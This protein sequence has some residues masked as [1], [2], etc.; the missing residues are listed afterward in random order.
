[1]QRIII[2]MDEVIA[3]PM[4]KM[5]EWYKQKYNVDVDYEKMIG[6]SWIKGFPEEHQVMVRQ[7]LY[8]PGFFRDLPVMENSVE[9][10]K[11]LNGRYEI[12]IV[13]AAVEF[14][15]SL[16]DK[17]DWLMEHFPFFTWRQLVL[18]G[19]KKMIAGDFMIDDHARHLEHF[20]GKPYLYSAPH[21]LNENRFTRLHNWLEIATVFE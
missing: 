21:N 13:S 2:D 10:L 20:K 8:E 16:K 12:Y 14:P 7:R 19:E 9:V 15:H 6:G 17:Y 11:Q 5:I 3:D 1:M 18:C 4:I